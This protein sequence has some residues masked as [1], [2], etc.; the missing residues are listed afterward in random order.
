MLLIA[1]KRSAS[2]I[3][4]RQHAEIRIERINSLLKLIYI[5]FQKAVFMSHDNQHHMVKIYNTGNILV[6]RRRFFG[7]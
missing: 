4:S 7:A 1:L 5:T 6:H 2:H 3:A